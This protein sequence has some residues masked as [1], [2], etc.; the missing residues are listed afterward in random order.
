MNRRSWDPRV[1]VHMRGKKKILVVALAVT[2]AALVAAA[3][4]AVLLFPAERVRSLVEMEASKALNM[5]VKVGGLGLTFLGLPALRAS[6]IVVG[7]AKPGEPPL[8]TVKAV[9]VRIALLPL[10]GLRIE[11]VSFRADAPIATILTRRD[12]SGNLPASADTVKE[13]RPGPP[14][15]PIPLTLRSFSVRDGRVRIVDE[16]KNTITTLDGISQELSLRIG[17][18][19]DTFESTGKLVIGS[20]SVQSG[21][22]ALPLAGLSI[23]FAHA[24][25]GDLTAGNLT[26]T[27]GEL[28]LND[29]PLNVTGKLVGWKAGSFRVDTGTVEVSKLIAALPDSI[30]PYKREVTAEGT[31]SLTL[32]GFLDLTGAKPRVT[33]SGELALRG[34]SAAVKGLPRRIDS[35]RCTVAITDS[36]LSFRDTELRIGGSRASLSGT[37]RDY[38]ARPVIALRTEGAL[39]FDEVASALP[40]LASSGLAGGLTFDL[41]AEGPPAR[42]DSLRLNGSADLRN[43]RVV[44][45]KVLKNPAEM[46]GSVRITPAAVE[47]A[48]LAVR[49]GKSDFTLT[50]R[51]ADYLNF[52]TP[53]VRAHAGPPL[54]PARRGAPVRFTGTLSSRLTDI[55]DML[56]ID[57]NAPLIKP[58]DLEKPLKNLPVPP[59]L[60]VAL[61]IGLGK[62]VF[63]KL[64]ADS[65]QGSLTL[66]KGVL[67]LSGLTIGAYGGA[68]TGNTVV[69]VSNPDNITYSGKFDLSKLDAASFI[70]SFFGAGDNFRGKFSCSL[71]FTGAGLDSVSFF[72]NLKGAG[73]ALFEDGQFVNWDFTKGLGG[74][75][76]FL[77]FDRLDFESLEA[78]FFIENQRV[79]TPALVVKSTYG[80]LTFSGSTGFDTSLAYDI[81][82]KL[83]TRAAGIAGKSSLG[84]LADLITASS[85]PELYLTAGG[86]LKNPKFTIDRARSGKAVKEKLKNE[87]EKLLQKQGGDV[88]KQ[89][90]KLLNKLFR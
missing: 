32:D 54:L 69:N 66:S 38:L 48:G 39:S 23:G 41:R 81:M 53:S 9:N 59:T 76:K 78:A 2:A 68:L 40:I 88:I 62:V 50:G 55:G 14:A 74:T 84:D 19:L 37:V 75:L 87:A 64:A 26:L 22:K 17:G 60:D 70:S 51:L 35:L 34:V 6:D 86:T 5:P 56:V 29:L 4:V 20:V 36:V 80:D 49:T 82:F 7:P 15:L 45:P 72:K 57:R 16:A 79:I 65:T 10:L 77:N 47:L 24:I 90:N 3:T 85:A 33:Y 31:F 63:G 13:K 1:F 43:L 8:L 28:S 46:S 61:K 73:S 12:G 21:G 11:I 67:A 25:T 52:F 89:Y 18:R 71:T 42:P 27:K 58:W 44:V 30:L 83:N